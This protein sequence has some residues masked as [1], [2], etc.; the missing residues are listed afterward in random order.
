MG[1]RG[2]GGVCTIYEGVVSGYGAWGK[3]GE[4]RTGPLS[5]RVLRSAVWSGG[6]FVG[7]ASRVARKDL[8]KVSSDIVDLGKGVV[9]VGVRGGCARDGGVRFGDGVVWGGVS[10]DEARAVA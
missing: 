2:S 4:G 1:R 9:F 10:M 8:A 5:S 7:R 3:K 6:S